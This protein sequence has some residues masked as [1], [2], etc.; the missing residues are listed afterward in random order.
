MQPYFYAE[1]CVWPLYPAFYAIL[2]G[3]TGIP[4]HSLLLQ[5]Q[6]LAIFTQGERDAVFP[7]GT[8]PTGDVNGIP[9]ILNEPERIAQ[10]GI[11]QAQ[12]VHDRFGSY[13]WT[14]AAPESNFLS[15]P[16]IGGFTFYSP[17]ALNIGDADYEFQDPIVVTGIPGDNPRFDP[18][19]LL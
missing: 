13:F 17:D 14:V 2:S 7:T 4:D 3:L 12:A 9:P 5:R 11:Q 10:N 18:V 19:S 6:G 8:F 16:L 1:Y 15:L